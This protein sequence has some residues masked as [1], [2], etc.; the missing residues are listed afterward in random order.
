M[1]LEDI[2]EALEKKLDDMESSRRIIM[3]LKANID[4]RNQDRYRIKELEE[5]IV[6]RFLSDNA[7]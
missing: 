4:I 5:A 6:N 7:R 3:S 2:L 1:E